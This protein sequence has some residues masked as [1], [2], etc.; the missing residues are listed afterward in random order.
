MHPSATRAA[1]RPSPSFLAAAKPPQYATH[2]GYA[3]AT[4]ATTD[5]DAPPAYSHDTLLDVNHLGLPRLPLPPLEATVARYLETLPPVARSE[6][7]LDAAFGA[8]MAF[9]APGG[10][11]QEL[12]QAHRPLRRPRSLAEQPE[13]AGE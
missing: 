12:A 8:A 13:G 3:S 5:G 7:E 10:D 2:R 6:A 4:A 1:H 9:V 11:G